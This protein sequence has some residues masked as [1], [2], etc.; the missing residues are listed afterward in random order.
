MHILFLIM[1]LLFLCI[2]QCILLLLLL[3]Q[4][5]LYLIY[6]NLQK[7]LLYIR[8]NLDVYKRRGGLIYIKREVKALTKFY[9]RG[10]INFYY[11]VTNL[12]IRIGVR[13]CGSRLRSSVYKYLLRR[14][15][16]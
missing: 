12:I 8:S 2:H 11:Y 4:V 13:I 7:K 16:L 14:K 6:Y 5:S 9:K 3:F 10:D 15:S 1:F